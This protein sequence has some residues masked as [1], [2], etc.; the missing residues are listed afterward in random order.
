VVLGNIVIIEYLAGDIPPDEERRDTVRRSINAEGGYKM[1][2]VP[3]RVLLRSLV[4]EGYD[5]FG[6]E[7]RPPDGSD[8]FL[9]PWGAI[10]RVIEEAK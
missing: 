3:Q 9:L 1:V 2:S 8:I 4:L 5:Q 10:L 6:L 7:V